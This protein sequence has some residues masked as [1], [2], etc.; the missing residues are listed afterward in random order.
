MNR[1]ETIFGAAG[2]LAA[3]A[4]PV[5]A[6]KGATMDGKI[7]TGYTP[8]G[9]GVITGKGIGDFDFLT[10]R[11]AIRHQRLKDG[12]TDDWQR[13]ES[14][15]VVHQVL[16]GMGSIEELY[17][18]D[19]SFMGMG[20]RVWLPEQKKWADHWT[21]AAN[22]VV[23]PPQLGAFIDGEGVFVSNEKVDDVDWLYRG[24]W[25]R[26]GTGGWNGR[27]VSDAHSC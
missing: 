25:D 19:G 22:G 6:E 9:K 20:V 5:R 17:K 8:L 23:N 7:D 2:L 27:D 21:S 11:W 4:W 3:A 18:A 26:I 1:R 12:S 14:Q 10:G 16:G 13:F 15:A 24:V